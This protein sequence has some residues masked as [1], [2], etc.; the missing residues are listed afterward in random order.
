VKQ[1]AIED[2]KSDV[3]VV[4]VVV[5]DDRSSRWTFELP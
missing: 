5:V 3:V 2:L 4:V 1:L